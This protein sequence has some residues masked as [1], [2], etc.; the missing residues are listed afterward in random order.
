[1]RLPDTSQRLLVLGRTGSGK[2]RAAYW[3][4]AQRNLNYMPW[5]V[6]NHKAEKLIDN[7]PGAQFVELDFVPKKPGLYIYHPIPEQDDERVTKLLWQI[8]AREN[9]G[10]YVDEGYM[11]DRKDP[12]M[13]AILTQGRSK[14]IPMVI[15]SQRPVWLTRFAVSESDFYQLFELTDR[16]DRDRVKSF[17]PT[18]LE[19]WMASEVNQEPKLPQYHSLYYDVSKRKLEMIKPVPG[20]E[21]MHGMIESQLVDSKTKRKFFI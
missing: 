1:M 21:V 19:Y 7:A 10:I 15:L 14:H 11:V 18:D 6:L 13:Q 9:A 2:T 16:A 3:H 5:I 8:H 17:I 4:L 12:A 20:D